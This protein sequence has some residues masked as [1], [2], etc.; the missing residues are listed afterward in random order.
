VS[1]VIGKD[2]D[3]GSPGKEGT[4]VAVQGTEFYF[5]ATGLSN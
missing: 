5:R 2:A 4:P 1:Q 3:K